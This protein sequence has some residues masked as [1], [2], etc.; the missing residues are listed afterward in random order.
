ME[1]DRNE[2]F[3]QATLRICS[4]LDIETALFDRL[5]YIGLFMPVSKKEKNSDMGGTRCDLLVEDVE[6]YTNS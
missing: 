4:S 3:R 2:F 5:R 1:S 6:V